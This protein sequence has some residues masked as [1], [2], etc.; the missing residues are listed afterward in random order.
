MGKDYF[1]ELLQRISSIRASER[2]IYQQITDIFAECCIDNDKNSD[3]TKNFYA[4]IQNKFHF[5]ISGKTAE[6]II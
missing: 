4:F 6:E 2:R 5:A 3:I 1:K